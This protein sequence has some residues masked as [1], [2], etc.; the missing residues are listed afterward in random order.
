MTLI[1]Q[2]W[3]AELAQLA[4]LNVKRCKMTHDECRST[5]DFKYAGQNLAYRAN[6]GA[7]EPMSSLI[8]KNVKGWYDEVEFAAQSDIDECCTSKSGKT[9]GHFTQLVTDRAIQVGCAVARY[10][11]G[12]W[13]TSLMACNYAFTNMIGQRVYISGESASGCT[14]GTNSDFPALCKASEAISATL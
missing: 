14:S 4:S 13:K 1:L 10:T 7:F 12:K 5:K 6:S 9:I 2:T 8:E 11:D 3:N